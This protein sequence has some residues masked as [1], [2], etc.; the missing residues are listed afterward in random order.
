MT[1]PVAELHVHLE[2]TLE[3]E[4]IM[5]LAEHNRIALPYGDVDELRARYEFTDLQSFLDLYYANMAVL[6]TEEDFAAMTAA[7]LERAAAGGVRHAEVFFDPQAHVG[8]GVP[9]EAALR[10]VSSELAGSEARFGV[11]TEL[12]V[13]F[14]R[15]LGGDA[16]LE[17]FDTVVA[18]GIPFLGVGLDSAEVGF[19]PSAF[20]PVF[21]KA[22]AAGLVGVAHAGEEGPPEYVWEAL[23]HLQV[24]RIDHGIRS[25]EDDALV[26]RLATERMPLTVCPLSNVRLQAVPSLAEHPISEMLERGLAVTINSDDPAYFGGYVDDNFAAIIAGHSLTG[27]QVATLARNSFEASFLTPARKAELMAEVDAWSAT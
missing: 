8:R 1:P 6:R 20:A 24:N 19:P 27:D 16:A 5:A 12:I 10:G 25:M 9:L 7:Y 11:S 22:R 2:G 4:L 18:T 15:D 13:C 21:A 3:P 14:L 17:T 23:D 26:E